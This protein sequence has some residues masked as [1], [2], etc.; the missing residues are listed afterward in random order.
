MQQCIP[1]GTRIFSKNLP[2]SFQMA[3]AHLFAQGCA[4][5]Y[6]PKKIKANYTQAYLA[7]Y[8]QKL[9]FIFLENAYALLLLPRPSSTHSI[10]CTSNLNLPLQKPY[11]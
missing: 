9:N 6:F 5:Q 2:D 1:L 11:R 7:D 4:L 10:R 3:N 8:R